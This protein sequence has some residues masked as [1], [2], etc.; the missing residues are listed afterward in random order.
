MANTLSIKSAR[1]GFKN[2]RGLEGDYNRAGDR[3]LVS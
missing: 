1:I 3:N 2:F